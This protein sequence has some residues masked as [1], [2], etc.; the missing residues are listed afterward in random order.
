MDEWFCMEAVKKVLSGY[1]KPK[2]IHR[3]REK[4]F[5]GKAS[6]SLFE[7]AGLNISVGKSG[8]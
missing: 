6:S 1:G 8:F 3:D 2:E 7:E 5:V 4:Q